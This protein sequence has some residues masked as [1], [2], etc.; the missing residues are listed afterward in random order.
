VRRSRSVRDG[1]GRPRINAPTH[2]P[3]EFVIPE[4]INNYFPGRTRHF[5]GGG[6]HLDMVDHVP[7]TASSI[8]LFEGAHEV[9]R[10]GS[11]GSA[12]VKLHLT[13][14]DASGT[15]SVEIE[16]YSQDEA[17]TRARTALTL[18]EGIRNSGTWTGSVEVPAGFPSG[19]Y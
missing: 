19:D 17:P 15:S 4:Q 10:H 9:T 18:R 3:D 2:N 5:T 16:Y 1:R 12:M 7:G 6:G 14:I 13:D 11:A 8:D